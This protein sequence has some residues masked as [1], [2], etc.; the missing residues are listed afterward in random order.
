MGL[1]E[2]FGCI[3][4]ATTALHYASACPRS[5]A[6]V[7]PSE[8]GPVFYPEAINCRAPIVSSLYTLFILTIM[9]RI[10]EMISAGNAF[11][12]LQ[13]SGVVPSSPQLYFGTQRRVSEPLANVNSACV[14]SC[15]HA[16]GYSGRSKDGGRARHGYA[17]ALNT[18][19]TTVMLMD[20][21]L[22]VRSG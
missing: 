19:S 9:A 18:A 3:L 16:L 4:D 12:P 20:H 8:P 11:Q 2:L 7:N 21:S 13:G 22:H 5:L 17:F 10:R 15:R 14:E 6:A 1:D